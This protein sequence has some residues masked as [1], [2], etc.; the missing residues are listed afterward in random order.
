M[1]SHN[2]RLTRWAAAAVVATA[3]FLTPQ[4]AQAAGTASNTTVTNTVTVNF[5]VSSVPQTAVQANATF[6]VDNKVDLTVTKD[7]DATVVPGSNNQ[8]LAFTLT[9]TGN[10]T[11]GYALGT[12]AGAGNT[13]SM[14]SVRIYRDVNGDGNF[15]GGD[16]L[17]SSGNVGDLAA[18]A[19]MKLLIVA[20][21]PA[22]ATNGQFALYNLLATTLNAGTSTATTQDA[23]ADNKDTVQVVFADAAGLAGS[24]DAARDGK[25]SDDGTYT[26]STATLTVTKTSAVISDPFNG[27]TNPKRIPGAVVRYTV[28]VTNTGAASATNVVLTDPLPANTSYVNGSLTLNAGGLTDGGDADA[29]DFGATTANTVT[30]NAGTLVATTGSATVTFDVTIN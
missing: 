6:V 25:G 9:N 30:V 26:V 2:V 5:N 15:D 13:T 17:Y 29:G 7:A 4:S 27:S 28:S 22:G 1:K 12:V 21:T 14:N 10:T 19:S 18:D 8:V 3:A 11:Q 24:G 23:G 16:T 20:N